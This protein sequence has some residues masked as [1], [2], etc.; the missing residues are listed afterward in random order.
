L[1]D[2]VKKYD[3]A[4]LIS[5]L[6]GRDLVLDEDNE[7]ILRKEKIIGR[8]F[9]DLTRE[10]LEQNVMKLRPTKRL[11]KFAKECKEKN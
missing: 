6:R 4:E 1:A 9:L 8:D 3:T 2:E 5:F 7:K 11:V 10:E